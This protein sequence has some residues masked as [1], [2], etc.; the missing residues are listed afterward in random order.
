MN[1]LPPPRTP[2]AALNRTA[3]LTLDLRLAH[4]L[5]EA[6]PIKTTRQY[7]NLNR[8]TRELL[9]IV[10]ALAEEHAKQIDAHFAGSDSG[11]DHDKCG[12]PDTGL[13]STEQAARILH[14][15]PRGVRKA[16]AEQRLP[17]TQDAGGRWQISHQDLRQYRKA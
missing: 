6:L 15:S 2:L 8:E 9:T 3:T 17:A 12:E 1:M 7:P 5:C 16:I 11:T 13:I 4:L 10:T 14:I